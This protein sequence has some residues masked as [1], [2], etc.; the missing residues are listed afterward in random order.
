[1]LT[2]KWVTEWQAVL[3]AYLSAS[4]LDATLSSDF[5]WSCDMLQYANSG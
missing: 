2:V 5:S 3:V 4:V 1:M